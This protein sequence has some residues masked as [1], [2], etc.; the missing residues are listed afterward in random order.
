VKLFN[1]EEKN[2]MLNFILTRRS[3]ITCMHGGMVMHTPARV[4]SEL[5]NGEMPL[6]LTDYYLVVGCPN[7]S[8]YGPSP[9]Q[10]VQ[11]LTASTTRLIDGVPV[12]VHTSAG[13]CQSAGNIPQ[14]PAI[15]VSFQTSEAEEGSIE[16]I[17][18]RAIDAAT[19]AAAG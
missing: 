12:L 1:R 11:W 4:P 2:F 9:C 13:I 18:Q 6:L 10:T 7:Q 17:M 3:V 15:I 14:G 5:I 19:K 8:P 16:S